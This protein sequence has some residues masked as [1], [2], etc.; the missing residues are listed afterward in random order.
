MELSPSLSRVNLS[1]KGIEQE[2]DGAEANHG[3]EDEGVPPLPQVDS[4]DQIVD[5]RESICG[6]WNAKEIH[7]SG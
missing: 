4:L 5:G 1:V 3:A 6:S 7:E 2:E